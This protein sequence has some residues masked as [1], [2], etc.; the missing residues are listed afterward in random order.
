MHTKTKQLR[1][2]TTCKI[3]NVNKEYVLR[4]GIVNDLDTWQMSNNTLNCVHIRQSK[5]VD[6]HENT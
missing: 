6:M 3:S 5:Y 4:Y 2:T 1:S